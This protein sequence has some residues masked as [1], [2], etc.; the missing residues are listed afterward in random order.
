MVKKG[1]KVKKKK[2]GIQTNAWIAI[3]TWSGTGTS[4]ISIVV[5]EHVHKVQLGLLRYD[6]RYKFKIST[7]L[8]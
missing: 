6:W 1:K 8:N 4:G 3:D 2:A 7:A 5:K